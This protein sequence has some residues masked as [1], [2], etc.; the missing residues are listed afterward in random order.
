[1]NDSAA[2]ASIRPIERVA[3]PTFWDGVAQAFDIQGQHPP[4]NFLD[5]K[6]ANLYVSVLNSWLRYG[7]RA[8]SVA[9]R[10]LPEISE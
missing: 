4:Y 8:R 5:D 10:R 6:G 1:M 9:A 3:L 2:R 7:A